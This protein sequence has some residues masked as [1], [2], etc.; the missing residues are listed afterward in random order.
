MDEEHTFLYALLHLADHSNGM[1]FYNAHRPNS[2]TLHL[3]VRRKYT[4]ELHLSLETCTNKALA[5]KI[6]GSIVPLVRRMESIY[7]H[8]F[9]ESALYCESLA[10]AAWAALKWP[11]DQQGNRVFSPSE[12]ELICSTLRL[13]PMVAVK[14]NPDC[15]VHVDPDCRDTLTFMVYVGNDETWPNGTGLLEMWVQGIQIP[16]RPRDGVAIAGA[17]LPHQAVNTGKDVSGRYVFIFYMPGGIPTAHV[18]DSS[19]SQLERK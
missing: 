11:D 13:F 18:I 9:K 16:V 5:L 2:R 8:L 15:E 17:L 19:T 1:H 12:Q 14:F 10:S 6:L 4:H 3:G 7:K